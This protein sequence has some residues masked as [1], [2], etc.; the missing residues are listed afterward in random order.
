M[1]VVVA[2]DVVVE[3]VV[4]MAVVV[5]ISVVVVDKVVVSNSV[6]VKRIVTSSF[7]SFFGLC[8]SVVVFKN[9]FSGFLVVISPLVV[10]VGFVVAIV[11]EVCVRMTPVV[12]DICFFFGK[13]EIEPI[14]EA[15]IC[16]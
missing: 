4:V 7:D 13:G 14:I 15:I 9:I 10:V 8:I 5:E 1:V 12:G 6:S 2:V 3:V 16:G 11:E